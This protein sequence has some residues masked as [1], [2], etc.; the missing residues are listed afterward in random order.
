MDEQFDNQLNNRI[1]EVFENFEDTTADESWV[2]LRKKFPQKEKDPGIIWLWLG[3]VAAMLLLALGIGTWVNLTKDQPVKLSYKPIKPYHHQNKPANKNEITPVQ[4]QDALTGV[5]PGKTGIAG[6]TPAQ[7]K[8]KSAI[9]N[10]AA[11]QTANKNT[12]AQ[13]ASNN[14]GPANTIAVEPGDKTTIVNNKPVPSPALVNDTSNTDAIH[15]NTIA[16]VTAPAP[17]ISPGLPFLADKPIA[18]NEQKAFK[19]VNKDNSSQKIHFSL[20][21]ATYFNYAKGSDN[22]VNIGAG[23]TSDIKLTNN[24]KLSTGVAIAQN[25][26]NYAYQ[27]PAQTNQQGYA[28][29]NTTS[30][31]S[32]SKSTSNAASYA[33]PVLKSSDA[34]L[35]GLDIP[36]NLKY[37]FNP[38]KNNSFIS[39]GLSSGTFINESYNYQYNYSNNAAFSSTTQQ[40]QTQSTATSF[41]NFYFAKTLNVSFGL[42]YSLGKNHLIVEPFLKYPLQGLGSQQIRFGAAGLNLKFDFMAPPKMQLIRWY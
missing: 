14:I 24:L 5:Y 13:P 30:F 6:Y 10:T 33:I 2:L 25:T 35:V 32:V 4:K 7:N 36:I 9:N 42:G 38:Q 37:E 28:I 39:V 1:R 41:S 12:A 22:R 17:S 11:I 40:T 16:T 19:P 29:P 15:N 3:A 20:Y 26:L 31:N 34:Q 8:V 27:V 18:K 21:E 23:V